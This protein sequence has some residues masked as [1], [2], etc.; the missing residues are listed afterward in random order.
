MSFENGLPVDFSVMFY[1]FEPP[2]YTVVTPAFHI[3]YSLLENYFKN[4]LPQY[5][6][7]QERL[8]LTLYARQATGSK[9]GPKRRIPQNPSLPTGATT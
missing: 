8:M 5:A 4:L 6:T 3:G 2:S 1:N 9:P 7:C